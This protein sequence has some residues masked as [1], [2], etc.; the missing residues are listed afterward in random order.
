MKRAHPPG[1]SNVGETK[2][3][4][5][6]PASPFVSRSLIFK[7]QWLR[8]EANPRLKILPHAQFCCLSIFYPFFP[9]F[10]LGNGPRDTNPGVCIRRGAEYEIGAIMGSLVGPMGTVHLSLAISCLRVATRPMEA[11]E[12]PAET[13]SS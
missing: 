2:P 13:R 6:C 7:V 8:F 11:R 4:T 9:L 10:I 12:I 5:C 3:S 1:F